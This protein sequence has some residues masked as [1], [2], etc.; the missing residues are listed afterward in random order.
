[1]TIFEVY[2]RDLPAERAA[3]ARTREL[4]QSGLEALARRDMAAAMSCF[5]RCLA[6]V[7]EDVAASNL[8]KNCTL[9]VT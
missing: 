3:K 5:R 8:L 4:L 6:L 1:V 9:G 2:Q 7:P